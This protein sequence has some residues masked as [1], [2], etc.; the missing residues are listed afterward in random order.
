MYFC[1]QLKNNLDELQEFQL[2]EDE[3]SKYKT[4][5]HEN[6]SWDKV[7]QYSQFI[8]LNHSLD[9]KICNY[10]L[11]SCF[12]LNNEECFEKLLLLFQ[13]LK[14]LID[15]NNAYILAQK[16]KIQNFIQNF[17]QEYNK[18][19]VLIS[20]EIV[21]QFITLFSEFENLLSCNFAKIEIAQ[22]APQ[23][24]KSPVTQVSVNI[25]SDSINSLNEREY[26]N[27]YQKLAFELLEEDENNLN[28]YALFTQAMWG[29]IRC[30]PECNNEKITK[31]RKPDADII[32]IL[33]SDKE[34]DIE[35]IKCFMHELILNPFWIEGVQLFCDFLE[36]KKKNKQLDI[37][38]ILTSDFISKFD[39]IELLRF[40]NGDFICKEEVYKYFVKSKENKKS[41]FSSKKTDKEHTLQD[42]EQ[43]LMNIDKENFNNSIM[44]NINSLL[45]MV[46]IFES[47]GMKKNSKILNIY[48]VELMEKTLLKD[49]LAEE[50]ENAKSKIK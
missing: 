35:H 47:K 4:L 8:L 3:M 14:K 19:K 29:K 50:Y 20:S 13:H 7:Y 43:M 9:F 38:I 27:F 36:K 37:L 45:D 6:I 2:L 16:R 44:N 48:L 34:N 15:E 39:T 25:R 33:L 28:I 21:N 17:I 5:N 49:Y 41:F 40:Q 1:D 18:T 11:L 32:R 42:F 23:L 12:N 22:V 31:I 26:K 46:K 30:L 24:P 10:F